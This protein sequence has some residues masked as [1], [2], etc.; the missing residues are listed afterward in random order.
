M[1]P[2]IFVKNAIKSSGMTMKAIS[3]RTNIKYG[4]LES[5]VNGR[6]EFRADE[7]L[8]LCSFFNLDPL[9]FKEIKGT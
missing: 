7:Y 8:I 1:N 5:C 9:G 4:I 6:R 3:E 2:E